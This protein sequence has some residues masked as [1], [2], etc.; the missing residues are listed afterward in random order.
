LKC[1]IQ[2]LREWSDIGWYLLLLLN[3]PLRIGI[4]GRS[5]GAATV[6]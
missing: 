2:N 3:E 1:V 5:M 4:W 6:L